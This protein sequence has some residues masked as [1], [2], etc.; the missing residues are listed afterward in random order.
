M[1]DAMLAPSCTARTLH[2]LL[3]VVF[4]EP[5]SET[6]WLWEDVEE[7]EGSVSHV[8]IYVRLMQ[9]VDRVCHTPSLGTEDRQDDTMYDGYE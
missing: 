4:G 1:L 5:S 8:A 6:Y 3:W 7:A 2:L 9:H